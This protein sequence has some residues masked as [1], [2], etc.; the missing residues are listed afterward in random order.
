MRQRGGS[1][2]AVVYAGIDPLTGKKVHLS[3]SHTDPQSAEKARIRLVAKVDAQ[4]ST[5]TRETLGYALDAWLEV[6][7]GEATTIAGYRGYIERTIS[8]RSARSRSRS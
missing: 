8:R 2:E 1:Y 4:R 7:E 6:H 3:E 5:A